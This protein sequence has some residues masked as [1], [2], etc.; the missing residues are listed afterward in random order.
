MAEPSR[1]D[2]IINAIWFYA[3]WLLAVWGQMDFLPVIIILL[4]AHLLCHRKQTA[5]HLLILIVAAIGISVDQLLSV[6]GF[7]VFK[8]SLWLP[9]WLLL[10]WCAFAATLRHSLSFLSSSPFIAAGLGAIGGVSSYFA[11]THFDAVSFGYSN[12]V[13]LAVI[14]AIWALLLPLFFSINHWL[15]KRF[16]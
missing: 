7:F 10:L 11:G 9:A 8:H 12:A 4:L 1:T 13:S 14:A 3:I 15:T 16:P 2:M 5:E 6:N